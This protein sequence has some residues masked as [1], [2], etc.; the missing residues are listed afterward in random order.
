MKCRYKYCRFG[1]EVDKVEAV[2]EGNQYYHK[3]CYQEKENKAKIRQLYV[4]HIDS[5][6]DYGILNRTIN[7]IVNG[8]GVSSDFLLFIIMY[9]IDNKMNINAPMG[10]YYYINNQDIK[11]EYEKFKA[12]KQVKKL[13]P[14]SARTVVNGK[15]KYN[16]PENKGWT[17]ILR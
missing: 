10:L 6:V 8:K 15:R 3:E 12:K 13:N 4:E 14:L 5:N 11:N 2:K 17:S 16:I 9:I 1:G 7:N